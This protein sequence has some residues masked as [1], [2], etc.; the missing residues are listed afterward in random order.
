M[1]DTGEARRSASGARKRAHASRQMA[2]SKPTHR[3]ENEGLRQGTGSCATGARRRGRGRGRIRGGGR[4]R[5][6]RVVD[7]IRG[8][9]CG[10]LRGRLGLHHRLAQ[11]AAALLLV[12][13][14]R[15]GRRQLDVGDRQRCQCLR[16]GAA[17]RGGEGRGTVTDG[18]GE[19]RRCH[20]VSTVGAA[21][22]QHWL[23]ACVHSCPA[24]T[25]N[26]RRRASSGLHSSSTA[27]THAS[28]FGRCLVRRFSAAVNSPMA[29]LNLSPAL[30]RRLHTMHTDGWPRALLTA[31][32]HD[33]CLISAITTPAT[34]Q[35]APRPTP[36]AC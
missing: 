1:V 19:G 35:P 15:L 34:A 11:G 10:A 17:G 18:D 14:D 7:D 25:A 22:E 31:R 6:E 9:Q 8:P 26:T 33:A 13:A 32:G 4:G 3:C 21:T 30:A 36:G 23:R 20:D 29:S 28:C 24:C 2:G 12:G 27:A 16:D 5:H